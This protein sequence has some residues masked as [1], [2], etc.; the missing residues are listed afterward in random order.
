MHKKWE[1]GT[2][3]AKAMRDITN[4]HNA[5]VDAWAVAEAE[6]ERLGRANSDLCDQITAMR[7]PFSDSLECKECGH[8]QTKI[9]RLEGWIETLEGY[10]DDVRKLAETLPATSASLEG[11][12]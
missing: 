1:P 5:T 6:A 7:A 4:E 11:E 10:V 8:K 9:Y 12:S 3:Y 2:L